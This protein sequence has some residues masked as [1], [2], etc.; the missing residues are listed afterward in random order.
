MD[1]T[2]QAELAAIQAA[3]ARGYLDQERLNQ[4]QQ[5]AAQPGS[6]GLLRILGQRFLSPEQANDLGQVYQRALTLAQENAGT[7]QLPGLPSSG[8]HLVHLPQGSGPGPA[9][10]HANDPT[11]S[12]G[13]P[14][15]PPDGYPASGALAEAGDTLGP[16]RLIKELA[17]GGMGVVYVAE[18][19]GLDRKVALKQLLDS[20]GNSVERFLIEA[21]IAA[22]L[23]HPN[24]VGIHDVGQVGVSPYF[25]MDFI[26]GKDLAEVIEAEGTLE[27]R[28]AAA[29]TQKLAAAL[30]YAHE[31][32]VLHRD[33]KPANILVTPQD[34]PVL[35]DFGLAKDVGAGGD[36]GLTQAGAIMGTPSYM[37][38]EQA[39]SQTDLIDRRADIYS[40][41]GTLYAMLTGVPPFRGSTPLNTISK[42]LGE[43]LVPP[44]KLR[45]SLPRDLAVICVKCLA[46]DPEERYATAKALADDLGRF[47]ANQ[48]IQ[49]RPPS[50]GD[51]LEKWVRRNRGLTIFAM[52]AAGLLVAAALGVFFGV[53]ASAA[54][55][56]R[57]EVEEALETLEG[58]REENAEVRLSHSLKAVQAASRYRAAVGRERSDELYLQALLALGTAACDGNQLTLAKQAFDEA[59]ELAP[60]DPKVAE[61]RA[62]LTRLLNLRR[63]TVREII[64]AVRKGGA[65]RFL[66]AA[67]PVF[68]LV[69]YP[70]QR[71]QLVTALDGVSE[72]L[73]ALQ[74]EFLRGAA[75]AAGVEKDLL[76]K[77]LLEF[78]SVC[79]AGQRPS[80]AVV[81][82]RFAQIARVRRRMTR[83][84]GFASPISFGQLLRN[85][86]APKTTEE[87]RVARVACETL[88]RIGPDAQDA[89][90][91]LERYLAVEPHKQA[92]IRAC[93]A[94]T[95]IGTAAALE[96][97]QPHRGRLRDASL[98][99]LI[100]RA[101]QRLGLED[102]AE[103]PGTPTER[104]LIKVRNA[105][106]VD[107]FSKAVAFCTEALATRPDD[108]LA[109]AWRAH[110]LALRGDLDAAREDLRHLFNRPQEDGEVL[111][112]AAMAQTEVGQSDLAISNLKKAIQ[113]TDDPDRI[114]ELRVPYAYLL[115]ETDQVELAREQLAAALRAAPSAEIYALQATIHLGLGELDEADAAL[116][117]ADQLDSDNTEVALAYARLAMKRGLHERAGPIY[118]R[119]LE[120]RR[121]DPQI[122]SER[123]LAK[124]ALGDGSGALQ[125]FER[126][127][128]LTHS[129][130]QRG[131][132]L[133]N[134]A[135]CL[136]DL[137]RTKDALA[138]AKELV[139]LRPDYGLGWVMLGTL[140]LEGGDAEGALVAAQHAVD[141]RR[142]AKALA[143]RGR[144]R[145]VLGKLPR[146]LAD[147]EAVV[148][149]EPKS[150][151]YRADLAGVYVTMGRVAEGLKEL[152]VVLKSDPDHTIA[153]RTRA[154][155]YASAGRVEEAKADL[156]RLSRVAPNDP[157]TTYVKA[158]V[159]FYSKDYQG[160]LSLV[161]TAPNHDSQTLQLHGQCLRALGRS[162]EAIPVLKRIVELNPREPMAYLQ[163][164]GAY[165]EAGETD[166]A[167][168]Q[169]KRFLELAP[170][171]VPQRA[172]VEA[173]LERLAKEEAQAV[174]R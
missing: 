94:L 97:I 13:P 12:S 55:E 80:D 20:G 118:D 85:H 51:R 174:G 70:D 63:E 60:Q 104:L 165:V 132:L 83:S 149:L 163:L 125:D 39:D 82:G 75:E 139:Q 29:L 151:Q 46:K 6:L 19:D 119:V 88:G 148:K 36:S 79:R 145:L 21:R 123:A 68:E 161:E 37:P 108:P 40:L 138:D 95:R 34:E 81:E 116:K 28:R 18:R 172:Q 113:R 62:E 169:M 78:Q 45:K 4:A 76:E 25:A 131:E 114:L 89:I 7:V 153:L 173:Y 120:R 90:P 121:S 35:T 58:V 10:S 127:L 22:R 155:L 48:P 117:K 32:A 99:H 147:L 129:A 2:Q 38:P 24:I 162:R 77:D 170:P 140:L 146:A 137:R 128:K 130:R 92:S 96:A 103:V 143:L 44:S 52:V 41:G 168:I 111:A 98:D 154:L 42:V 72:R 102:V 171:G 59:H 87:R 160:A 27:P 14:G 66:E 110:A 133:F 15:A 65:E 106:G 93:A 61:R 141:I 47:L 156:A 150:L 100:G 157:E 124:A 105:I 56:A 107:E 109:R 33:I 16:Y 164:G 134:R 17:R 9:Q 158:A 167:K 5:L 11:L 91:A 86:L 26:E 144:L 159:A 73:L 126:A 135:K 1:G 115:L 57:V 142:S 166:Q 23:R 69:R 54:R 122:I 112:I 3:L 30:A 74:T 8:T 31:R 67:D 152:G 43:P 71:A 50:L 101:A 49:A 53:R 84:T 136:I 64:E